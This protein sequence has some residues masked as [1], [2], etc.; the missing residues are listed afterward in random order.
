MLPII[1]IARQYGS[2]GHDIGKAVAAKLGIAFYDKD[3]IALA[4]K[5]S[6]YSEEVFKYVDEKATNSLLYSLVMGNYPFG[7]R[8]MGVNEMPINDK[9]FVIQADII[10]KAAQQGPCVIIGRCADYILRERSDLMR[11]FIHADKELRIKRIMQKED[12][13][14]K[15][16]SDHITK[17]DKQ[18]ANYYSF[19]TSGRW[20]ELTNYDMI[21]NS[22]KFSED[23]AAE[24]IISAARNLDQ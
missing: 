21:L 18:R 19:Y 7:G 9:L 24:L 12:I 2:G 20:D 22:G 6:G 14:E 23:E 4:A 13:E 5:E 8:G 3:L 1:T 15:R 17:N 16:V 10:K 11:I